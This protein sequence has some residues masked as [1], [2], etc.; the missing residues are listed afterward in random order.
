MNILLWLC[1]DLA[2]CC[3]QGLRMNMER[4]DMIKSAG[5]AAI[6]APLVGSQAASAIEI[7]YAFNNPNMGKG[8]MPA[9]T[10]FDHRGCNRPAKEYTGK[11]SASPDD[12]MCIKVANK[13]PQVYPEYTTL[14]SNVLQELIGVTYTK[15][16]RGADGLYNR[17]NGI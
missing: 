4:R 3:L 9:I 14:A 13:K 5:A 12:E 17:V 11:K 10:I 1:M 16:E 15:Y 8:V 6:A 7:G 2:E